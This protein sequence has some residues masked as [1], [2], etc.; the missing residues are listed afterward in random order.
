[1]QS[2]TTLAGRRVLLIED[3]MLVAMLIEDALVSAGCDVAGPV[4]RVDAALA[5]VRAGTKID[6]ALMDLNLNGH[7]AIPVADA[8]REHGIPFLVLTGY[9]TA[10]LPEPHQGAPV[11]SKPF[12]ATHLLDSLRRLL[13][14]DA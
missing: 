10:A 1:M 12:D 13:V 11:I 6:A 4:S 9:G 8:L 2:A 3:E 5:M 7:S 14:Q